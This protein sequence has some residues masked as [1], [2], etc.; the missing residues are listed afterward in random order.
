MADEE[1][2]VLTSA[3]AISLLLLLLHQENVDKDVDRVVCVS[4]GR[5]TKNV[6]VLASV[7]SAHAGVEVE[8]E[9]NST[10]TPAWTDLSFRKRH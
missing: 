1:D 6:K 5:S 8:F 4:L 3:A 9:A 7:Q 10:T 2:V